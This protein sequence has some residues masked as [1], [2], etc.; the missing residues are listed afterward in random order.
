MVF[1]LSVC[2]GEVGI[3]IIHAL[4]SGDLVNLPDYPIHLYG[5]SALDSV[6]NASVSSFL[7]DYRGTNFHAKFLYAEDCALCHTRCIHGHVQSPF[8]SIIP[9]DTFCLCRG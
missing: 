8:Y 4:C 9:D 6:D 5:P 7:G 3:A 2:A 1:L